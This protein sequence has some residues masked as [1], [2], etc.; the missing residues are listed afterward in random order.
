MHSDIIAPSSCF[1]SMPIIF[2]TNFLMF[3]NYLFTTPRL[4]VI[5]HTEVAHTDEREHE[6]VES[7]LYHQSLLEAKVIYNKQLHMIMRHL[8]RE[9]KE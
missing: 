7:T 6:V 4:K 5:I 8:D 9:Y 2:Q 1:T 3:S